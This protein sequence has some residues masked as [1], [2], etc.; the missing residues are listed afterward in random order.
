[1]NVVKKGVRCSEY[2]NGKRSSLF[3]M[4]FLL[5]WVQFSHFAAGGMVSR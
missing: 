3:L 2:V 5:R 1:M 4:L